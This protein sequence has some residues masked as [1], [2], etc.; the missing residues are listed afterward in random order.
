MR[1]TGTSFIKNTFLFLGAGEAGT[2][3]GKLLTQALMKAR[4]LRD[5]RS[6]DL[7]A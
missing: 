7:L 1:L 4:R 2:G 6:C 5:A 3:I